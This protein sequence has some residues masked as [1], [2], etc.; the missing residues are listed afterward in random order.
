MHSLQ[1]RGTRIALAIAASLCLLAAPALGDERPWEQA[2]WHT[3]NVRLVS[4][5]ENLFSGQRR[6]ESRLP[7][8]E[9]HKIDFSRIL[10]LNPGPISVF[11]AQGP[12]VTESAPGLAFELRF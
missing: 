10:T 1:S 9:R 5:G 12:F 6:L 2:R 4:R 8:Y 3:L 7:T 11:G